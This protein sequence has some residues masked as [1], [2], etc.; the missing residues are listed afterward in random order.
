MNPYWQVLVTV[1]AWAQAHSRFTLVVSLTVVIALAAIR[2]P[3]RSAGHVRR[4]GR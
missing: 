4:T 2:L 3:W 1:G